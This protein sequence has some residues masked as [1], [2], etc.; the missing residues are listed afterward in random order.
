MPLSVSVTP[1]KIFT[2]SELVDYTKLNLLGTPVVDV[3]GTISTETIGDGSVTADKLAADSVTMDKLAD[4]VT[5]AIVGVTC[6]G[7]TRNLVIQPRTS[8]TATQ[9]EVT[10]D[11]AV[12]KHADGSN[13]YTGSVALTGAN[14]INIANTGA[15]GLDV[16]PEASAT[17]YYIW[18]IS[19]GSSAAGL[20]S[21]SASDPTLPSGYIYKLRVGAVRNDGSGDFESFYQTDQRAWVPARQVLNSTAPA[22]ADTWE[23]KD[24]AAYVPAT[25][26]RVSG[27]MGVAGATGYGMGV[28][29]SAAGLGVQ[30]AAGAIGTTHL[31][32]SSACN[33]Q[34]PLPTAQTLWWQGSDVQTVFWLQISGWE[35]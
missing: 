7:G 10:A 27:V 33:F 2:E 17:W 31:G 24:I 8:Y 14:A 19:N 11:E 16:A 1:S 9:V 13:Y 20:L 4:D 23:S 25:A 18:L 30:V 29:G 12:L 32:Y 35:Y 5:A 15:N 22:V 21:V 34:V 6:P 26:R 28:A 3:S